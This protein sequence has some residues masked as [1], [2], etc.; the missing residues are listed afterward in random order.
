[1]RRKAVRAISGETQP[2]VGAMN[3]CN[4]AVQGK[5]LEELQASEAKYRQLLDD[6]NDGCIVVNLEG[7]IVFANAKMAKILGY[8]LEE[9]IG[10]TAR[11]FT[12]SEFIPHIGE[13]QQSL[14]QRRRVR[15][16]FEVTLFNMDGNRVSVEASAKFIEYQGEPAVIA[17]VRDVTK[18]KE[19]LHFPA[20]KQ[21]MDCLLMPGARVNRVPAL[22]GD[23]RTIVWSSCFQEVRY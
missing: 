3:G 23:S 21:A 17:V 20:L 12:P 8:K 7:K 6:I 19:A 22:P 18:R 13:I 4:Q 14:E 11:K 1:M 2:S 10:E 9:L 15:E 16:R 5:P